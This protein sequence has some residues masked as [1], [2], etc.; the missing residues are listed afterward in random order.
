FPYT[1]LF[2]SRP[3]SHSRR[4]PGRYSAMSP[5][6][7]PEGIG[8]LPHRRPCRQRLFHHN[9][10]VLIPSRRI[11]HVLQM[12]SDVTSLISPGRDPLPL[13]LLESRIEA[14]R[15]DRLILAVLDPTLPHDDRVSGFL[16]TGFGVG[17]FLDLTLHEPGLDGGDGSTQIPLLVEQLLGRLLDLVGERLHEIAPTEGID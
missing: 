10:E 13:T 14:E 3:L 4:L 11:A 17:S 7:L 15:L 5:E 2:R 6:D 12:G 16:A 8:H 9:Q 1:P